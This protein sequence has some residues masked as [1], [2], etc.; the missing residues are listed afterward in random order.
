MVAKRCSDAATYGG[1][2]KHVQ[3]T[4]ECMMCQCQVSVHQLSVK[5]ISF[6]GNFYKEVVAK[7]RDNECG[8]PVRGDRLIMHVGLHYYCTSPKKDRKLVMTRMRRLGCLLT[9]FRSVSGNE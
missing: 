5:H 1:T 2:K 8:L 9:R 7:L 3:S 4:V 6:E